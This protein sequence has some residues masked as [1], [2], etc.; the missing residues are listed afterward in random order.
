MPIQDAFFKK[1]HPKRKK[2]IS[3]SLM[4]HLFRTW[5]PETAAVKIFNL[6]GDVAQDSAAWWPG[7]RSSYI[8][9][10]VAQHN[11]SSEGTHLTPAASGCLLFHSC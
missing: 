11:E 2:S 8:K 4:L 9:N 7:L 1:H 10:L 5:G 6:A 3:P